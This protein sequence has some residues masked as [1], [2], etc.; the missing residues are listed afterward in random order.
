LGKGKV[1]FGQVGLACYRDP[2]MPFRVALV[3]GIGWAAPGGLDRLR[4]ARA[5]S[6]SEG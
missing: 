4:M 2:K 1:S 3:T 6:P 5:K